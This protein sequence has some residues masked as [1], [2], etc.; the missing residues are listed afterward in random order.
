MSKHIVGLTG[1]SGYVAGPILKL[2]LEQGHTVRATVRSLNNEPKV[3]HLNDL[4][5]SAKPGQLTLFEADLLKKKSFDEAFSGCDV[6]L[7]TASPF[8]I[9]PKGDLE[10]LLVK[11][12]VEGTS[13]VLDSCLAA[14]TVKKVVLTSSV[15]AIYGNASDHQGN[16]ATLLMNESMWNTTS[17]LA[18]GAYSLSKVKAEKCAWD[19]V[20]SNP[21]CFELATINPGLVVGPSVSGLLN[22]GSFEFMAKVLRGGDVAQAHVAAMDKGEGRFICVAESKTIIEFGNALSPDFDAYGLPKTSLP[23]WLMYIFGPFAG[24]SWHYVS[25]NVGIPLRFNNSKIKRE[26]GIDFRNVS[27]SLKEMAT[28]MIENGIVAKK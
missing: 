22:E 21:G 19:F 8:L 28:G 24:M 3:K 5:I 13:N 26:L 20:K 6:V 18:N 15:V 23:K 2:L 14:G 10:E 16:G 25:N 11:P 9:A 1:A 27:E 12:A 17:N 4:K 7:H